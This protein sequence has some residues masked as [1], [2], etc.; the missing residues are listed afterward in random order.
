[1]IKLEFTDQAIKKIKELRKQLEVPENYALRV[2]AA[3]QSCGGSNAF[4]IGFDEIGERDFQ[5]EINGIKVI[6]DPAEALFVVGMIV[7]WKKIDEDAEGF[8][9]ID[10]SK[11]D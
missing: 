6:L 5:E 11:K 1:M 8:L 10:P 9:F 2:G 7:D 3:A 4:S